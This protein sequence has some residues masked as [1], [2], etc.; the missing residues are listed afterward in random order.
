MKRCSTSLVSYH[1]NEISKQW[2]ITSYLLGLLSSKLSDIKNVGEGVEKMEPLCIVGRKVNWF[3]HCGKQSR[4]S[5]WKQTYHMICAS[6]GSAVKESI[7]NEGDAGSTWSPG[8]AWAAHSSILAWEIPWT[9]EAG[10]LW[11][12]GLQRSRHDWSD[13]APYEPFLGIYPTEINSI[14]KRQLYS[15]IYC[16]I[17]HNCCDLRPFTKLE[18]GLQIM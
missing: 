12:M 18:C 1:S 6:R 11:S 14:L 7:C 9:E 13:R 10:G 16:I 4:V 5:S 8:R 3:N 2:D 15:H 17:I